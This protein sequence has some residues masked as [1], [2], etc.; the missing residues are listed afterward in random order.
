MVLN[1]VEK[2]VMVVREAAEVLGLSE[3]QGWRL[4]AAYRE[5]G[6]AGL[7]HG[8]RGRKPIHTTPGEICRK[9]LQLAQTTYPG[10][11]Q[12]HFTDLL[13]EREG[14]FLHRSTVRRILLQA[15]IQ[16]P[17]KRRPSKHRKRRERYAPEGMLF[18]LDGSRHDWLEGRGPWLRLITAIDDATGKIPFALF[19][20]QEDAQGYFLL[21][22]QIVEREGIPLAVYR[23]RH[24]IFE[25]SQK[26]TESLEEELMGEK[27]PTQFGRLVRELE[28]ESIPARSPQAK[29]RI[30]RVFRTLQDRLV[31]ELRLAG[32]KTLAEANRFLR[33]FLP[34][35]NRQFEVPAVQPG[36]A[37][38]L[39]KE[40]RK[41][42]EVFC[43]KY[44]RTVGADNVVSFREDRLQIFP[45]N[46]RSSY[47]RAQVEVHERMD[48]S[49]AVYYQGKCLMTKPAPL[50]TPVLRVKRMGQKRTQGQAREDLLKPMQKK[51]EI[52][53]TKS[54][55]PP[56]PSPDHPWRKPW[57]KK[58]PRLTF[59]MNN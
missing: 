3:R 23:D 9:I 54:P 4:L 15:G 50:E 32:V 36:V 31:S 17:R 42:D 29:G 51:Q 6:A 43:F 27:N 25:R 48:G 40:R 21:L 28:I 38:R 22:R 24:G 5:E 52:L 55:L 8:N 14:V 13:G 58:L 2:G 19:R 46:G 41:L 33:G 7:A 34:R 10:F 26:E 18:Q 53:R 39:V 59:S 12:Q 20:E 49:L 30:E 56:K 47:Y 1:Q 37:Y 44:W 11:N 45:S 57:K 35:F 16:S